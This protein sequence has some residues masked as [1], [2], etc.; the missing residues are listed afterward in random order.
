MINWYL[1]RLRSISITE[2]PY[3]V[4]QLIQKQY[5]KLFHTGKS[6]KEVQVKTLHPDFNFD[7]SN[8]LVFD[9]L[10]SV[11]GKSYNYKNA[12]I[13]W[14]LDIFSGKRFPYSFSKNIKLIKKWIYIFD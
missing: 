10:I 4:K 9:D 1:N 8:H 6:I 3:R 5:E 14:H 11:F 2:I 7:L 12:E 13:D